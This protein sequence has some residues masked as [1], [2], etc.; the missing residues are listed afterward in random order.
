MTIT[1]VVGSVIGTAVLGVGEHHR[2][3]GLTSGGEEPGGAVDDVRVDV[4]G[5]VSPV[6]PTSSASS[7]AL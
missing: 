4:D 6:G 5:G 7:A 1:W 2:R 3:L